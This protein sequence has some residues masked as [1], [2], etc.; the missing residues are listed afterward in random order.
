MDFQYLPS[1]LA[2]INEC[3]Q[4]PCLGVENSIGKN[5]KGSYKCECIKG[6]RKSADGRTCEGKKKNSN[7]TFH[8]GLKKIKPRHDVIYVD[9][10]TSC[11]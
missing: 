10:W 2:D 9:K 5:K 4:K 8:Y 7:R 6:F 1:I 11:I 3:R